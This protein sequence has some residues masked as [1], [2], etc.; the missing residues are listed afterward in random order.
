M[1]LMQYMRSGILSSHQLVYELIS[2]YHFARDGVLSYQGLGTLTRR[3]Y[4]ILREASTAG[5]MM[6]HRVLYDM[7]HPGNFPP[8][9]I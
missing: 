3:R 5:K 1:N 7:L 2:L 9:K 4:I 8:Y 6:Y